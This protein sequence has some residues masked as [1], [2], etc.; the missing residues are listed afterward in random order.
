MRRPYYV[1]T[2][3]QDNGS[4]CG[5]SSVRNGL[6]L[7]QDWYR[8]GG[9]D[10]FYSQVDP[11]DYNIVYAESQGGNMRR[12]NL[13]TGEQVSIRPQAPSERSL[14]TNIRPEPP[15]TTQIRWNWNTPLLLSPHNPST[16]YAGANR[17]FISRDRGDT[18]TMTG[19]LT[20]NIDRNKVEVMG[21]RNDLPR[22]DQN[23]RG[24][25]CI[26]SRNDG[27][28]VYG[29]LTTIAESPVVPG[30]LWVGSDDGNIQLSRDGGATWTE[31]GK[32]VPGGTKQYYV[33]RVEA[34]YFDAAVAYASLDGHRSDDLKPYVFV[35]RDYGATWTSVVG[36]LPEFGNVNTVRQ[37]PKNPTLLYAGTEFGF[38]ISGDEGTSWVRF[39]PNL[40]VVRIDDVLVHPRDGDL[41]LATHGRS[42][43]IMDDIT[44]LQETRTEMLSEAVH[45][46]EPREAVV[47]A[48]DVQKGRYVAG[49][50][51]WQGEN[52]PEGAA[53][54]YYMAA[55][56][57]GDATL[58]ISDPMTGEA[59]RTLKGTTLQGVNRVQWDL[60]GETPPRQA[61]GGGGGGGG[62]NRA[63]MAAPGV[64][65]VT[66]SV[67]GGTYTSSVRV[68]AD[69]WLGQR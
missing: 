40:P 52:A 53:I 21:M 12:V 9:G 1:C 50:K 41:V 54:H 62:G 15:I 3:L 2:G 47:W 58:T 30:I 7:S 56:A 10:G 4:W 29:T 57:T 45:L 51:V 36:D 44:A 42:V 46:F 19:D 69:H 35:T 14:E 38:Y 13:R 16:L 33:S 55:A 61:G 37:D 22:C 43:W 18:W 39:M 60:R 25:K 32:N 24:K 5:P 23:V 34:S 67:G 6:I 20:R 66:L 27:V 59:F 49:D 48:N 8:V 68:L 63:P 64:Y 11:S 28:S 31:V 17:L 26:V 65:R